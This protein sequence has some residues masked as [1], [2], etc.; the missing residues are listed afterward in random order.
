MTVRITNVARAHP[1]AGWWKC[2]Y[3]RARSVARLQSVKLSDREA[4]ECATILWSSA[5]KRPL[6]GVAEAIS[7][8]SF[9]QELARLVHT[10]TTPETLALFR[11]WMGE[12][13]ESRWLRALVR[14]QA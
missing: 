10:E 7:A 11:A 14:T 6:S 5:L 4:L 1:L 2:L 9:V 12:N 3:A 8:I 13:S